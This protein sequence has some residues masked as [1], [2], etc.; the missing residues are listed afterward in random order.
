MLALAADE[1]LDVLWSLI[2]DEAGTTV[3]RHEVRDTI[4]EIL[5]KPFDDEEARE[6]ERDLW[7]KKAI[8]EAD[9]LG[10][11]GDDDPYAAVPKGTYGA[12][13]PRPVGP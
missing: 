1:A 7:A 8:A 9:R 6:Y 12:A 5:N 3:P 11:G 10:M 4:A 13:Q 2:L